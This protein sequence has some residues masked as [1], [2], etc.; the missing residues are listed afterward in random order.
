MFFRAN[1]FLAIGESK[2][3]LS[4]GGTRELKWYDFML[5][6]SIGWGWG[7]LAECPIDFFKTQMQ[8]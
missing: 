8:I 5:A 4:K 1:K 2:R 3:Y 6:G 7:A